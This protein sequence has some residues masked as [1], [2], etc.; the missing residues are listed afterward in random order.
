MERIEAIHP[1]WQDY[2]IL[3]ENGGLRHASHGTTG[4]YVRNGDHITVL[5]DNFAPDNFIL[6]K[7]RLIH[8]DVI[9]STNDLK[10]LN[11]AKIDEKFLKIKKITIELP[12]SHYEVT[13][14][15]R[16]SD[17]PT[18]QQVFTFCEYDNSVMP[19]NAKTIVDLGANIGLAS[20]YFGLHYPEAR[21]LS[22]EPEEQNFSLLRTNTEALGQR[23]HCEHAAVWSDDGWINLHTEDQMGNALGAWGVQVSENQTAKSGRTRSYRLETLLAIADIQHVDILKVDIEGAELEL[24]KSRAEHWLDRVDMVIVETHD[25]FRPGSEAAVRD[26]LKSK[27]E[28]A[29]R[30]GE[31]L[32]FLRSAL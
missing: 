1:H 22:V 7:N 17:I 19:Q 18:F 24:F 2:L 4:R 14:R 30:N 25:R 13:L 8:I 16:T 6:Q 10:S 3:D 32:F 11:I 20:V 23:V 26:A 27:F 28:E 9:E 29:P 21:I 5:W 15:L 31:N 12:E